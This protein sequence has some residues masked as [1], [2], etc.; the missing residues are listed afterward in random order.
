[1]HSLISVASSVIKRTEKQYHYMGLF[2]VLWRKQSH[3]TF[4]KRA[5]ELD[6]FV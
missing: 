6:F 2:V 5:G 1:M 4:F 3:Q